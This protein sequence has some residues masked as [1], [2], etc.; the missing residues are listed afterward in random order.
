MILYIDRSEVPDVENISPDVLRY[1]VQ[2]AQ[3]ANIRYDLLNSYYR[4]EHPILT[5][6][7]ANDVKVAVNYAKYVV[8]IILGYYLGETVKYDANDRSD[9]SEPKAAGVLRRAADRQ[10]GQPHREADGHLRG[11]AGPVQGAGAAHGPGL[12][13]DCG[14]AGKA[15]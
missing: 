3:T 10:G 15:L 14:G 4:G 13:C 2:M 1:V 5:G 12:S 8:D 6:G 11:L 7:K 9:G